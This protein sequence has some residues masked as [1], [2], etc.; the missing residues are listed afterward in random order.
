MFKSDNP[1]QGL[2]GGSWSRISA[3][4]SRESRTPQFLHR[5]PEFRFFFPKNAWN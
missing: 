3:P 1:D 2:E 5:Y 4:F